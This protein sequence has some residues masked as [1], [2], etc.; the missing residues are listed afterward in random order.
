MHCNTEQIDQNTTQV[1]CFQ[2][3]DENGLVYITDRKKDMIVIGGN[4]VYPRQIEEIIYQNREIEE[5][6][7]VGIPDKLWEETVH[8]VAVRRSASRTTENEIINWA[9]DR[10][11]TDHRIR[12]VEFAGSIP[13]NNYGKV[14]RRAIRDA[15]RQRCKNLKS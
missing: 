13:S 9:R 12:S 8:L 4:N 3:I 15:A 7:I 10:L 11:P 1:L 5:A 2:W 14:L 6:C